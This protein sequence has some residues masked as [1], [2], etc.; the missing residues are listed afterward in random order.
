MNQVHADERG[1]RLT[2]P[3]VLDRL[4]PLESEIRGT[5]RRHAGQRLE[6]DL[7]G[8]SDLDTAGAVFLRRLPRVARRLGAELILG[9]LP[10]GLRPFYEFVSPAGPPGE[11]A[12]SPRAGRMERLGEWIQDLNRALADFLFA[13]SDLTWFSIHALFHR[14]GIRKGSFVDQAVAI[15]SQGLPIVSL[16]LFLIGAVSSLQAA[17][18]LRK[19]G[20]NIY[21]AD[22]LA[23]GITRELGPLM[24]AIIVSGRS[25]SAIAAEI[26]SMKFTEELD[27]LRTMG[28]DPLR[29]AAVPKMWAMV[30]CVPMLTI[31][32]DLVGILGG[33]LIGVTS[34]G[35]PPPAF[36]EQV[37]D[38]LFLRDIVTG[39]VKSFSFAWLITSIAVYRGLTFS[40]GADGVGRATTSSV[41]TSLFGIIALDC[42]WGLLFYMR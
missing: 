38:S 41:V 23:I 28:L 6:V 39:L 29:F 33:V 8:V 1:M 36:V 17:A 34:I 9:S 26:A 24:T 31:M 13:A 4:G 5:L 12:A 15:G 32:A 21:V 35:V 18:Q 40:G 30:A 42:F 19:F 7:S 27:A 10:E 11:K 22:L 2:G 37:V 14:R 20:A 16:I 25:G 3:L